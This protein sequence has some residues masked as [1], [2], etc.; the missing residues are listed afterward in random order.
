MAA[1]AGCATADPPPVAVEPPCDLICQV[2]RLFAPEPQA[3]PPPAPPSAPVV[4]PVKAKHASARSKRAPGRP[5]LAAV[6]V[7]SQPHDEPPGLS[8][9]RPTANPMLVQIPGSPGITPP[10]FEPPVP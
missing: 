1:L 4:Q 5:A 7:P 9:L 8:G 10:W 3:P 6:V 2:L